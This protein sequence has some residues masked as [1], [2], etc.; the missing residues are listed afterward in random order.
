MT[1]W[2]SLRCWVDFMGLSSSKLPSDLPT[3]K[4]REAV[5]FREGETKTTSQKTKGNGR[6]QPPNSREGGWSNNQNDLMDH[7][8]FFFFGK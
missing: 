8:F 2:D 7:M 6:F 1:S 3:F 4:L 5:H